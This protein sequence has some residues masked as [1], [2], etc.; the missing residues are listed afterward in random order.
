MRLSRS[1]EPFSRWSAFNCFPALIHMFE[2][3]PSKVNLLSMSMPSTFIVSED[4]RDTRSEVKKSHWFTRQYRS[5][6]VDNLQMDRQTD[7]EHSPVCYWASIHK[8]IRGLNYKGWV[9]HICVSKQGSS[10]LQIMACPTPGHYLKQCWNVVNW[11]LRNKF[12]W[13]FDQDHTFSLK[14]NAFE[15][16][17]WK[18]VTIL[19]LPQCVNGSQI[20]WRLDAVRLGTGMILSLW[21][22]ENFRAIRQ[23]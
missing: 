10:S 21:K 6:G 20:S 19:S 17:V 13:N 22:L 18:M 8:T 1:R 4:G 5:P 2:T 15:N 14:E 7:M 9:M 12:Q 23:I 11:T 16:V 3:W